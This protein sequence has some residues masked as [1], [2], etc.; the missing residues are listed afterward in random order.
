VCAIVASNSKNKNAVCMIIQNIKNWL[1]S[2]MR[3]ID[4]EREYIVSKLLLLSYVS[5]TEVGAII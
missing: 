4:S 1:Y 2:F 5:S 3:D